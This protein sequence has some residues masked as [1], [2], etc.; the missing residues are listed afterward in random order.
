LTEGFPLGINQIREIRERRGDPVS[1]ALPELSNDYYLE[2][3]PE[4][5]V[6]RRVD[7]SLVAAFSS[8]GGAPEAI[9]RAAEEAGYGEAFAGRPEAPSL[10]PPPAESGL[11]VNF[12][13]RFELL[14]NGEAVS[15]GRNLKA[16]AI[17]KYLLAQ[18]ARPVPQ[19][20][21][22]GWLWPESNLKRARWSLNSAIYA[23]RKFLSGCLPS[24]PASE[25]VLFEGGRY[26]LSPRIGLSA[27]TDEFDYHREKGRRL[28]KAGRALEAGTEYE[29]A[30]ELYRDDYLIEDLYE[31]WTMIE[32]QRLVDAYTDLL[33]GLAIN[34]METGQPWESVRTCYRIL[35]KDRCDEEAHRL[36]MECFV[37]LG[38]R[39]R[40]LRQYGL[41]E[42]ALRH[43]CD[44][45]PSPKIRALY[46]SILK[47]APR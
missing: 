25:T 42:Q 5:L 14:R 20:Y 37:R 3:D 1:E 22:M 41:C 13:G 11:R 4:V 18:R 44:M 45:T 21:L 28:E 47:D 40:A 43:E 38:Q 29:R 32:R 31:E 33:R 10:V 46:T 39:A 26:R 15:L 12:F 9:R 34:Y 2:R 23:L 7:G 35:E 24:L 19:D 8:R 30:L 17:L 16:I 36:L 27:D 6:L